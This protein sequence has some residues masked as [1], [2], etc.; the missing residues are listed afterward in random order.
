MVFLGRV[1][2][3]N[4]A[5]QRPLRTHR[6]TFSTSSSPPFSSFSHCKSLATHSLALSLSLSFSL[7]LFLSLSFSLSLSLSLSFFRS[8]LRST[9][10]IIK[11]KCKIVP[12]T[13]F[14]NGIKLRAALS[15]FPYAI[16]ILVEGS[17]LRPD[18]VVPLRTIVPSRANE[19]A[20]IY[21]I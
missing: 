10:F 6:L 16:T 13:S 20:V 3:S 21:F 15:L 18:R 9:A 4:E 5:T 1:G 2:T 14:P 19:Q 12:R 8:L 7:S 17:I 11:I